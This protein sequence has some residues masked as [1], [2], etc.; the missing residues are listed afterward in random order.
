VTTTMRA[1]RY[2]RFGSA[3]VLRVVDLP[4]P[5]IEPD[6][7][8]VR[9]RAAGVGGGEAAIRAGK[10]RRVMRTRPPAGVGND[11]TGHVEAIGADVRRL[12]GGDAVWGLMPHLTFGSTAEYVAVPERLLVAAPGNIDLVEAAALP[13]AGTTVV[14]ALTDKV[15]VRE[16]QRLLV[17]GAGGGVGSVAVQLG[18]HLGAHVTALV[19]ARDTDWVRDLG[20]HEAVDYRGDAVADLS[21]FDVVL[22]TVGTDLPVF[23]RMLSRQG[24]MIALALDPEHLAANFAFLARGA[25]GSSRKVVTFSNNPST[26]G[27][28]RL[29]RYVEDGVI[30]PV[31]DTVL[32]LDGIAEAHRRVEAGGVRGKYVIDVRATTR[33]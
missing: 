18:R 28:A 11:F 23:R 16:G 21:P 19:S 3:D 13:S 4:V 1:V 31:I 10:L 29:T 2:E 17:R 6:E 26:E 9:V 27:L 22:D 14:T 15:V 33:A 8:L 5:T 20:A 25:L 24:R 32:P 30:R 7:V 12:R